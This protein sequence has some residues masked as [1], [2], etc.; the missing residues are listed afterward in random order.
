MRLVVEVDEIAGAHVHRACAEAHL[1]GIDPVEVD[2][3]LKRALQERGFVKA[4]G[5]K[6]A[7][8]VQPGRRLPQGE[9]ARRAGNEGAGRAK[10]VEESARQV[11]FRR[12]RVQGRERVEQRV[13]GD[14]LPERAQFRNALG[15]LVSRDD[16]CIDGADRDARDPIGIDLGLGKC[17]VHSGLIGPK[18]TAA[19][20]H[21]RDAFERETPF[22][23]SEIRLELNIHD[24]GFL[25]K[26][27]P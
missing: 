19:L 14:L 5:L 21:K 11:T 2:K 23:C 6:G 17:L 24:I 26:S 1:A 22:R 13:C 20:Q 27:A 15:R 12:E 18:R 16:G 7:V 10:L 8:R 25:L 4:R 3:P 9:E